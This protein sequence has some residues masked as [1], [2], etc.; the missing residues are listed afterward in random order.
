MGALRQR[1]R[2]ALLMACALPG[3][4]LLYPGLRRWRAALSA[5]PIAETG[6]GR[7][8]QFFL[9]V[10]AATDSVCLEAE[11]RGVLYRWFVGVPLRCGQRIRE[12]LGTGKALRRMLRRWWEGDPFRAPGPIN[13]SGSA[14]SPV[15]LPE[16]LTQPVQALHLHGAD[17]FAG[18]PCVVLAHN[19]TR[20][21]AH[22]LLSGEPDPCLAHM[23]RCLHDLGWKV[24]LVTT[25]IPA[26]LS[27]SELAATIKTIPW[28]AG[29]VRRVG[30]DSV[31]ADWQA[32]LRVFPSLWEADE[33]TLADDSV[34]GGMGSYAALHGRMA[35]LPQKSCDFWGITERR[36][37][38]PHLVP[39]HLVFRR[40]ALQHPALRH[41]LRS[42]TADDT[43]VPAIPPE[44]RLTP[45]L[46]AAGLRPAALAP[47]S[48]R[49]PDSVNPLLVHWNRL[50]ER[51]APLLAK[52]VLLHPDPAV[53]TDNWAAVAQAR[54]Y[55]LKPAFTWGWGLGLDLTPTCCPGVRSHQWPND[56]L[57][58]Q[59]PISLHETLA[60]PSPVPA[61]STPPV[62]I[63]LHAYYTDVLPEVA[64][65][66]HHLPRHMA[67]YVST[68]T[69]AKAAAIR[70]HFAPMNFSAL[71]VRVWPNRGWDMAPFL[72]GFSDVLRTCPLMVRIHAKRSPHIAT[73]V[74]TAWRKLLYGSLLGSA[75]RV[76]A[77]FDLF[78][79]A[80]RLGM[81]CPPH[82]HHY[83]AAVRSGDNLP[84]MNQLLAPYGIHLAADTAID[85]PMGSMFW[86][87]PAVLFPW[88]DAG[89]S[90]DDFTASGSARDGSLAHALER[91]FLFGCGITGHSWGRLPPLGYHEMRPG[92][93]NFL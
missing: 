84:A 66:L 47:L 10:I 93:G 58:L 76:Q 27:R 23:G 28:A 41:C 71:D 61:P 20:A 18:Q 3:S 33:L 80:P 30:A 65:A 53:R 1:L 48:P 73:S 77:I 69:E 68:D 34:L 5:T 36:T 2:Q 91:L 51:G 14:N 54:K 50:L 21:C 39:C 17:T 8:K 35:L 88:L 92:E 16:D 81:L 4:F 31:F 32:A 26:R 11:R 86:C 79:H 56:V 64:T 75:Q 43:V 40:S 70:Q 62:G 29:V 37:P 59:Q 45:A 44:I 15:L 82:L 9:N 83:L 46:A 19:P 63:F 57:A 22:I 52:S 49:V 24:V 90:F 87:R 12:Q 85:F 25:H 78:A 7:T 38:I 55:P 6:G 74:S 72:L 67:L 60:E 42:L 89:L 13:L